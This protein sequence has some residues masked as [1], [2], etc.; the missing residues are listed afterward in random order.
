MSFKIPKKHIKRIN[1]L[2]NEYEVWHEAAK[3]ASRKGKTEDY[4]RYSNWRSEVVIKLH[5]EYGLL[6]NAGEQGVI[7]RENKPEEI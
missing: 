6:P 5:E 7:E 3:E 1:S 4:F 2:L